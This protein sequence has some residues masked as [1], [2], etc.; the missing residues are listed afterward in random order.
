MTF[1]RFSFSVILAF[2]V[3]IIFCAVLAS[4]ASAIEDVL[5]T[6]V[7]EFDEKVVITSSSL[8]NT[9]SGLAYNLIIA[10]DNNRTFRFTP[11]KALQNGPYTL[12]ITATDLLGNPANFTYSFTVN[13]ASTTILLIKPRIGVSNSTTFDI[14]IATP[15][16][17]ADCKY[18]STTI[19]DFN[20]PGLQVFSTTDHYN[21]F[22]YNVTVQEEFPRDLFVVCLD[23]LGRENFA[24]F[25]LYVDLTPPSLSSVSFNPSPIV[26]YPL[27]GDIVSDMTPHASEP[28]LCKYTNESS[29]DYAG[30]IAFEGFNLNSFTAYEEVPSQTLS[31]PDQPLKQ[32]YNFY[33]RCEDRAG[34]RTPK[35]T[36][37]VLLDLTAALQLRVNTPLP[38]SRNTTVFINI[39]TNKLS[40]CTYKFPDMSFTPM[41][42]SSTHLQR[43]HTVD[44]GERPSGSYTVTFYCFSDVSGA[45]EELV[46]DYTFV[47]DLDPPSATTINVTT[48][49]CNQGAEAVFSATD[50]L[51]GIKEYVWT[52]FSA[53]TIFNNG[54]AGDAVTVSTDFAGEQIEF[55][56]TL[57]YYFMAYAVDNAGNIGPAA[58][59]PEM[60]Y[61]AT[62]LG[63][64]KTPPVVTLVKTAAGDAVEMLC[65]DDLSG[66]FTYSWAYHTDVSCN[67]SS[68]NYVFPPILIPLFMTTYICY[69]VADAAG[70]MAIGSQLFELN[71]S[72]NATG[73]LT[74]TEGVDNDGD[75]YGWGCLNG[76][77]CDD[78]DS[79]IF[80][81]CAS[82]CKQDTDGDG[83]GYGCT[84]G[85][86]CNDNSA[87][88]TK[89]CANGCISDNDGDERGL[90]CDN[91]PD[92]NGLDPRAYTDCPNGCFDDNDGDGYGFGCQA[93]LDC[94]GEND[95]ERTLCVNGCL[96]DMDGDGYGLGCTQG[97]D[98]D[99]LN[100]DIAVGCDNNCI[101]D[102]DS[103]G[104]GLGCDDGLDCNGVN[105]MQITGCPNECLQDS[106]GDQ[107]GPGCIAGYDCDDFNPRMFTGCDSGCLQDTDV[108]TYGLCCLA[109][110]DCDD[111]NPSV[112]TGCT[113]DCSFDADCDKMADIWEERYNLS[114]GTDDSQD[115]M[116][117]DD[118]TNLEEFCSNL[119]PTKKDEKQAAP[120][121]EVLDADGDGVLDS[122]ERAH[123]LALNPDDPY[124]ADKDFDG[125]G[126]TNKFECAYTGGTCY[127]GTN[128][129][130]KDTDADGYDDKRE[131]EAGTD[132]CDPL[133]RPG[134]PL[135]IIFLVLGLLQE[136][137]AVNWWIY[138]KYYLPLAKPP[139]APA[140]PMPARPQPGMPPQMQRPYPQMIY[141]PMVHHRP[142]P[143]PTEKLSREKFLEEQRRKAMEREKLLD[144]F[145]ARAK[146]TEARK[147]M[148][149]IAKKKEKV[150]YVP[151][152]KAA[153]RPKVIEK[154]KEKRIEDDQVEKLSKFIE[155]D[156]FGRLTTLSKSQVDEFEK[157][158]S[159]VSKR[160]EK[161]LEEDDVSKLATITKKIGQDK[162]KM[163]MFKKAVEKT[164][165]DRLE[166]LPV[167]KRDIDKFIEEHEA[168][169]EK[170]TI[171]EIELLSVGEKEKDVFSSLEE[172][173]KKKELK[174]TT[175]EKIAEL[176][177]V[178]SKAD[179]ERM[180]KSISKD[181]KV[182]KNVFQ[183][184]LNY[185][186]DAGKITKRDVSK[187]LFDLKEQGILSDK[188]LSEVF[189]N[190]GIRKEQ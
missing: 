67:T 86:D 39:T 51:S 117:E 107:R 40:Y 143:R 152:E 58:Q 149:D 136:I 190:L 78:T 131:V 56:E 57:S 161:K 37:S 106:D 165:I 171:E 24:Q 181:V 32:T 96:S 122:C 111:F 76:Y 13:V 17:A 68:F 20:Q 21:H 8:K 116:D 187:I 1:Q 23:S 188:D 166:E 170:S 126:L 139:V 108:D 159:I 153:V 102:E 164:D 29:I 138:K 19:T 142:H 172:M 84:N 134:S 145:G 160:T 69:E 151:L 103:D 185:L 124:D 127:G 30:M 110:A 157:L 62:G 97:N 18:R 93:G 65:Q 71:V 45:P 6:I 167:A 115:N 53:T 44:V 150:V 113:A 98:C 163:G 132:P 104:S 14:Q 182:D 47:I 54:T 48:P 42:S 95:N 184:L 12:M 118:F 121:K 41:S 94:N 168:K 101:V 175:A 186:L 147:V 66:C 43:I 74:C 73:Q 5:P 26:E 169:K 130:E 36:A 100:P 177:D 2:L 15:N 81:G 112:S 114:V 28:V 174:A 52:F 180:I 89:V 31:F 10:T 61:D 87:D 154:R 88:E 50:E 137:G 90:G 158:A 79:A 125:D 146:R 7:A 129:E 156:S 77:D 34:W 80:I 144:T 72:T 25:K 162:E 140:R 11:E 83:F 59:S 16:R 176:K 92:C 109:G 60:K 22:S 189:F 135:W 55:N 85:N 63:C 46:Q 82:G 70:N 141:R 9:Q 179:L 27:F 123:T 133:S 33:V 183:V 155:A 49:I 173:S 3:G 75:G 148:E 120:Q 105:P 4:S 119:D 38:A 91:G 64:D 178:T 99:G 128:P 35:T